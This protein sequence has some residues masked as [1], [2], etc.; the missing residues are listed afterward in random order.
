MPAL[1]CVKLDQCPLTFCCFVV[2]SL[3][4]GSSSDARVLLSTPTGCF[5]P[6]ELTAGVCS[7][8]SLYVYQ[9]TIAILVYAVIS[10]SSLA[11]GAMLPSLPTLRR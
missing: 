4:F 5:H 2:A 6:S 1:V 8:A 7:L 3:L 10:S 11:N 9:A